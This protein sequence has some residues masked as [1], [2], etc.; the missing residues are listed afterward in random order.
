MLGRETRRG[1]QSVK[2]SDFKSL[3]QL[4]LGWLESLIP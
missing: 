1:F 2:D 4:R 3:Q